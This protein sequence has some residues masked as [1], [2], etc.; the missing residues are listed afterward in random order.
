MTARQE[1]EREREMAANGIDD[2]L[3]DVAV[4][5]G[6]QAGLAMAWH[7]ARRAPAVCGAGR[8]PRAW[9][10]LALPVGL[11]DPV[12]PCP[13]QRPARNAI[14]GR[15]WHLPGKDAV[16]A[17]L[18]AYATAFDLPARLNARVTDLAPDPGGLRG[19]HRR[20]QVLRPAR[21]W[22]RPGRSR[23]PLRHQ[24]ARGWTVR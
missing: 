22:S 17:Y 1:K 10:H 13:V 12:H 6:S 24:P 8:R 2:G 9:A 16:A 3:L 15:A 5:G 18:Q 14:P 19:P 4:I 23:S 7:L 21:W 11:A 20:R